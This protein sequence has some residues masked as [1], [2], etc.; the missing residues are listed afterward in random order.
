MTKCWCGDDHEPKCPT[1][2]KCGAP[3]E[4]GF[5]ALICPYEQ[6][7]EFWPIDANGKPEPPPSGWTG[8]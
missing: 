3:V 8:S 1:C 4:T 2:D 7:C 5:M 6:A